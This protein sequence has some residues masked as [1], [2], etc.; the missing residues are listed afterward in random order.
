MGNHNDLAFFVTISEGRK[1][2]FA[3]IASG[4]HTMNVEKDTDRCIFGNRI[5]NNGTD[6]ERLICHVGIGTEEGK[7]VRFDLEH[8]KSDDKS[9]NEDENLALIVRLDDDDSN[10]NS[11]VTDIK[12]DIGVSNKNNETI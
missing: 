5:Y 4:L 9:N 8:D 6:R 10:D 1:Y 3:P 7:K 11:T 2:K 12:D